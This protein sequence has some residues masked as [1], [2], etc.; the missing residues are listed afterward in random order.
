M[1]LNHGGSMTDRN[2]YQELRAIMDE[3][4]NRELAARDY[5]QFAKDLFV[6]ET[7]LEF[8]DLRIE[9]PTTNGD[10]D[11]LVPCLLEDDA[12]IQ[13]R[14]IYVWE[15]K[16][17]QTHIFC[18]DNNNRVKP[19]NELTKAENQLLH[20]FEECKQNQQFRTEFQI[21]D[22]EN[23]RLGGILIGKKETLVLPSEKYSEDHKKALYNKAS[24][25]R[26]KHFYRP[27]GIKLLTWDKVLNQLNDQSIS[28]NTTEQLEEMSIVAS[29]DE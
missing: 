29:D 28:P 18:R 25:Y 11:L 10:I 8:F 27:S 19:T 9:Y 17:P 26:M 2:I 15:I 14:V 23:V 5:I 20:Y 22:P 3:T 1:L 12:G 21:V 16:S 24:N 6:D 13:T 7:P 4:G